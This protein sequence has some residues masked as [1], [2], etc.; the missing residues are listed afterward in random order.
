MMT[1]G[2]EASQ[3]RAV[4]E[5]TGFR[6]YGEEA[7]QLAVGDGWAV[8]CGHVGDCAKAAQAIVDAIGG[9]VIAIPPLGSL[10]A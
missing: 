1:F 4:R 6:V 8:N 3:D 5:I 7:S 9:Q 10:P 2:S